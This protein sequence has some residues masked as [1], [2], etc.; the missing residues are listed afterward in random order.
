MKK[1]CF[2]ALFFAFAVLFAYSETDTQ[3]EL[4]YLLFMPNSS[5]VFA[6]GEQAAIQLDNLAEYLKN[7]N[8]GPGQIQVYGYAADAANN[9]EPMDLSRDRALFVINE[10][11]KRGVS[12]Y[13]FSEPAA[14]GAVD[15]W[16]G[17]TNEADRIPNRRVRIMLEGNFLSPETL[18]AIDTGIAISGMD[19]GEE[20]AEQKNPETKSGIKIP[21]KLAL[22][23]IALILFALILLLQSRAKKKA[24]TVQE[25]EKIIPAVVP[26]AVSF[27]I[28]N[29]EE[30]IRFCAYELYQRRGGWDTN[31]EEDW[32]T[33]VREVSSR[34][35]S[36]AYEIHYEDGCWLARRPIQ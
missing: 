28:V 18:K 23:L 7:K 36:E 9:I 10:L 35:E 16:G 24:N 15:F 26:K 11:Q 12:N 19:K 17:N 4:D 27:T 33:A 32:H 31:A 29:L 5:T 6:A 13:L 2:L 34:Y 21:R 20:T 22:I 14:Y 30:E 8:I 25:A 3:E 1:I